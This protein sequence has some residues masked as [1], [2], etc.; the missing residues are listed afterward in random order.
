MFLGEEVVVGGF[1]GSFEEFKE[2]GEVG[3]GSRVKRGGR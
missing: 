2:V 1:V 3:V